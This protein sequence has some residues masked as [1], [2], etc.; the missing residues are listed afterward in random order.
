MIRTGGPIDPAKVLTH[1]IPRLVLL[2]VLAVI[3]TTTSVVASGGGS[4][5]VLEVGPNLHVTTPSLHCCHCFEGA[6]GSNGRTVQGESDCMLPQHGRCV[7][8][9]VNDVMP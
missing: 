6:A 8:V 1:P 7:P 9:A 2:A 3:I 5:K 4:D